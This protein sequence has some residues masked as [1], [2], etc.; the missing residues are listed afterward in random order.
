MLLSS[1]AS[2]EPEDEGDLSEKAG[3]LVLEERR[4]PFLKSAGRSKVLA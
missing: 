2:D 1:D 3:L 4:L